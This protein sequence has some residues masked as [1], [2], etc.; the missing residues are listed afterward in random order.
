[1]L[2]YGLFKNSPAERSIAAQQA[3]LLDL[4]NFS[5]VRGESP[6][7]TP[8]METLQLHRSPLQ[9]TIQLPVGS[10]EGAYTVGIQRDDQ[11]PL[12]TAKGEGR[13]ENQVTTLHVEIDTSHIPPGDYRLGVRH[14]EFNWR[15]YPLSIR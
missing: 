1:M 11:S 3:A 15:Y 2:G 14:A 10:E 5:V 6:A 8:N 12:A 7:A 13:I 4:R 9:L